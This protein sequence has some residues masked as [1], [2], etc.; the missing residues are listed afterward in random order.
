MMWRPASPPLVEYAAK[1]ILVREAG[2][3]TTALTGT[4]STTLPQRLY[5]PLFDGRD[6]APAVPDVPGVLEL[7]LEAGAPGVAQV[8]LR[9]RYHLGAERS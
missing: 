4:A 2:D 9:R 5:G 7:S 1:H 3:A 6:G 8:V